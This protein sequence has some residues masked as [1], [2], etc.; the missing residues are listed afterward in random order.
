[1]KRSSSETLSRH[2][3]FLLRHSPEFVNAQGW[4]SFNSV[5]AAL[6]QKAAYSVSAAELKA[7]VAEDAKGRYE[8]R[9]E[10]VRAV[11]GHSHQVDLGLIPSVP[12]TILFHGTVQR[13][14]Q[15]I[16]AQGLRPQS[17]THVHLSE[18]LETAEQ[19]ATRRA[20][21]TTILLVRAAEAAASGTEFYQ[22]TN[23]VWLASSVP[24]EFISVG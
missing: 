21:E 13:S 22:S 14:V 24:A 5:L 11:Q 6:S 18:S 23:G 15:A 19:V 17:R 4:A 12:P 9:G 3:A 20:G 2:L 10:R 1:M 16:I 7:I 8:I